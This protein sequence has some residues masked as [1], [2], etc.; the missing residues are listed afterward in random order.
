MRYAL[1]TCLPD[2]VLQLEGDH[3]MH[4]R[5]TSA[6]PSVISLQVN[7]TTVTLLT[8]LRPSKRSVPWT[9]FKTLQ[10][11]TAKSEVN[12]TLERSGPRLQL[13]LTHDL[14]IQEYTINEPLASGK[15]QADLGVVLVFVKS[16]KVVNETIDTAA[17][18][19]AMD[20]SKGQS[21]TWDT[22]DETLFHSHFPDW[23]EL[24]TQHYLC[25]DSYVLSW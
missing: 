18:K 25:H 6:L 16:C 7:V 2:I 14:A 19:I 23:N 21:M 1:E 12:N 8:Q 10:S 15:Q 20:S 9:K 13:L 4:T 11:C 22:F 5:H 3:P 24:T 17:Y